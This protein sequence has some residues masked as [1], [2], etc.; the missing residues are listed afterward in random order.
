[1]LP[2]KP[3]ERIIRD[4]SSLS[5]EP[6][7]MDPRVDLDFADTEV[8][9][10]VLGL[11]TTEKPCVESEAPNPREDRLVRSAKAAGDRFQL[12]IGKFP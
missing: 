11:L 6:P 12:A 5:R 9:H 4:S 7:Q 10:Q 1:M 2:A 8:S 3:R